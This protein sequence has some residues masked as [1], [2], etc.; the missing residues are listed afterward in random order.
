MSSKRHPLVVSGVVGDVLDPFVATT[1]LRVYSDGRQLF[2]GCSLRP[3]QVA[4]RPRVD[5]GGDD[6][7]T[8]YTLVMVD[9]DSPSPG[10]PYLREYLHWLVTD[11]PG[12]TGASFG[13]EIVSYESP[14][15]TMGIH[16]IALVLF[17]QLGGRDSVDHNSEWRHNFNT[18]QF[19][20]LHNLGPPV[21]ALYYNCQ[22]ETAASSSSGGG[23]RSSS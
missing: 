8:F 17:R 4:G 7:R 18:R 15:P 22:R 20:Q 3:A 13:K 23:A 11:I 21:A 2:N 6:F 9:A 1:E 14:D 10:N 5:T 19:S 12:S 16:R